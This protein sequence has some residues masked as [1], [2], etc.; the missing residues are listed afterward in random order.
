MDSD[1]YYPYFITRNKRGE[2]I[3]P[4]IDVKWMDIND[5]KQISDSTAEKIVNKKIAAAW[6]VTNCYASSP[7][8]KYLRSLRAALKNYNQEIDVFG[9]CDANKHC[10]KVS[11]D[12]CYALLES[13]YYFY[14]SFENSFAVD[15]VTEKLMTALDYFTVPVVLGGANYSRYFYYC[16]FVFIVILKSKQ[17]HIYSFKPSKL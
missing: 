17:L 3:G 16:T 8:I 9:I 2:V 15:Y 14:L 7:R 12:E 4:N 11:M 13:D 6:F 5:M 10:S 1:I